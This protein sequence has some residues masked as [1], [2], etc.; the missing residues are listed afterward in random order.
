MMKAK[1]ALPEIT[2]LRDEQLR[3]QVIPHQK[4]DTE[5]GIEIAAPLEVAVV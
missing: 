5:M 1:S 2:I 3:G 4:R